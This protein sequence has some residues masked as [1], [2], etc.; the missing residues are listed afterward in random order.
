MK[1]IRLLLAGLTLSAAITAT[2]E[3]ATAAAPATPPRL[4][5][6]ITDSI[7]TTDA[8]LCDLTRLPAVA[9]SLP[10][11]PP[12]LTE[13]DVSAWNPQQGRWSLD[14]AR[15]VGYA[16][17]QKLQDHCF[18]LAIDG[19]Y[20][21]S[22]VALSSYSERLT[23]FTTLIITTRNDA[24]DLQLLS[25]NHGRYMRLIHVEALDAVLGQRPN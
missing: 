4:A 14:P 25:S 17:A 11:T 22:G 2:A 19:K 3:P 15:Y 23:G 10:T 6:W 5:L 9:P 18:V 20:V 13:R 7:G 24:L 8:S 1:T 21:N 16:A 12:T